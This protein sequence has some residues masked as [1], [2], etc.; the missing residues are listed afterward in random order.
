M[1]TSLDEDIKNAEKDYN[2]ALN[3]T[4]SKQLKEVLD[5]AILQ[6]K[7]YYIYVFM[8]LVYLPVFHLYLQEY[9]ITYT[10]SSTCLLISTIVSLIIYEIIHGANAGMITLI[11]AL[12]L[13]PFPIVWAIHCFIP[14]ANPRA[15]L[16][17]LFLIMIILSLIVYEIIHGATTNIVLLIIALILFPFPLMW[18]INCIFGNINYYAMLPIGVL[19]LTILSLIIYA[20]NYGASTG[21]ILSI[22]ALIFIPFPLVWAVNCI[23][24][25]Y[26]VNYYALVAS[27]IIILNVI[28]LIIYEVN[29]GAT[30]GI[31]A[32]IITLILMLFPILQTITRP[33]PP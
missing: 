28:I 26:D 9:V 10:F 22:L 4:Q 14:N 2:S 1:K 31:I 18:A 29:H 33:I 13:L 17:A 21:I 19:C 23:L 6:E 8:I 7:R 20:I 15:L 3:Q 5:N 25:Y 27:I 12:I 30:T 24:R 32:V 16:P 11:L